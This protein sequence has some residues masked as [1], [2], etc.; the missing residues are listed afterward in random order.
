MIRTPVTRGSRPLPPL[1]P[2]NWKPFP[3]ATG[4]GPTAPFGTGTTSP[5]GCTTKSGLWG[6]LGAT[7]N[8]VGVGPGWLAVPAFASRAAAILAPTPAPTP[9]I[10]ALRPTDHQS[11]GPP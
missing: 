6:P 11:I 1:P 10:P 5:F 9:P 8:P 2:S 7:L 4:E 3:L